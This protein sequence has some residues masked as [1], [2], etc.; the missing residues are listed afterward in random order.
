[1]TLTQ[2]LQLASERLSA[3]LNGG[4]ALILALGIAAVMS[5]AGLQVAQGT[6]TIGDL[7]LANGLILQLSGPLQFLGF[8]YRDLRQSQVDLESLFTILRFFAD[9]NV[10]P[11]HDVQ[12]IPCALWLANFLIR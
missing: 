12:A 11:T 4:Q 2:S 7:V 9:F 6:M 10:N 5:L 8:L 3:A 1:V